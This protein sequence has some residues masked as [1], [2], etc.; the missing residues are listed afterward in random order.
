M[1][2]FK[3]ATKE[4]SDLIIRTNSVKA[5]SR[6]IYNEHLTTKENRIE[7]LKSNIFNDDY[8]SNMNKNRPLNLPKPKERKPMQQKSFSLPKNKWL[9]NLDWKVDN[10]EVIFHKE[11]LIEK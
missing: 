1:D 4:E 10:T 9:G 3:I 5:V 6:K 8:Q 7:Q 2:D 11:N